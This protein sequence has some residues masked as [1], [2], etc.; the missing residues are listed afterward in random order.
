MED[1]SNVARVTHFKD[2][3]L[4]HVRTLRLSRLADL[5]EAHTGKLRLLSGIEY[6]P[7][8]QRF[9]VQQANS[10]LSIAFQDPDFRQQGLASDRFGDVMQFFDLSSRDAHFL[11]CYCHYA[12]GATGQV[13]AKRMRKLLNRRSGVGVWNWL[14]AVFQA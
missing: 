6:M 7:S 13:V 4:L 10:P 11:F 14:R 9:L 1:V 5:L 12:G 2:E 8:S 3:P